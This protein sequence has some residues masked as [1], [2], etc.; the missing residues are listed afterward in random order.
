MVL[1]WGLCFLPGSGCDPTLGA[2]G[3]ANGAQVQNRAACDEVAQQL[4]GE[5]VSLMSFSPL[6]AALL[7]FSPRKT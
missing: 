5:L 7:F 1:G 3:P 2:S 4:S 6:A